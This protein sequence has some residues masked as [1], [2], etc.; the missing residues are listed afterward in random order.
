MFM[1]DRLDIGLVKPEALADDIESA[2]GDFADPGRSAPSVERGCRWSV[3]A[4]EVVS[5]DP[6]KSSV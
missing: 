3:R 1:D 6:P 5:L 4:S 2:R